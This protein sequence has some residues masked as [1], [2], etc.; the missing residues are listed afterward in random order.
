MASHS[1]AK[2]S[3]VSLVSSF[4]QVKQSMKRQVQ[5]VVQQSAANLAELVMF[6]L[7]SHQSLNDPKLQCELTPDI[8]A[9]FDTWHNE[10]LNSCFN[11]KRINYRHIS[12]FKFNLGTSKGSDK[13]FAKLDRLTDLM[14]SPAAISE[15]VDEPNRLRN[16][17]LDVVKILETKVADRD[18]HAESPLSHQQQLPRPEVQAAIR[19]DASNRPL[20]TRPETA[21]PQSPTPAAATI[22]TKKAEERRKYNTQS[23]YLP[24][25]RSSTLFELHEDAR[26][27]LTEKPSPSESKFSSDYGRP[28][29]SVNDPKKY[30]KAPLPRE[31][32]PREPSNPPTQKRKSTTKVVVSTRHIEEMHEDNKENLVHHQ[33]IGRFERTAVV[34][35]ESSKPNSASNSYIGIE[36]VSDFLGNYRAADPDPQRMLRL[37]N[38]SGEADSTVLNLSERKPKSQ[39]EVKLIQ[40]DHQLTMYQAEQKAP[41]QDQ[42]AGLKL[43]D[44]TEHSAVPRMQTSHLAPNLAYDSILDQQELKAASNSIAAVALQQFNTN[45]QSDCMTFHGTNNPDNF[46]SNTSEQNKILKNFLT[47]SNNAAIEVQTKA[48]LDLLQAVQPKKKGSQKELVCKSYKSETEQ[49]LFM[50]KK[51]GSETYQSGSEQQQHFTSNVSQG[52]KRPTGYSTIQEKPSPQSSLA[53]LDRRSDLSPNIFKH[54]DAK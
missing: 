12:D 50:S 35:K 45:Q 2:L 39:F 40:E 48:D 29:K 21:Q 26:N 31:H 53:E 51:R 3:D 33:S 24:Q 42:P 8:L 47:F 18:G 15:I 9:R 34:S 30:G 19:T 38:H 6:L 10:L 52:E 22:E 43:S 17:L 5:E 4:S 25:D 32:Q 36:S 16:F 49:A 13:L 14:R 46:V 41:K 37:S 1:S 27:Y 54:A 11:F 7:L 44:G 28:R 23:E 20:Q